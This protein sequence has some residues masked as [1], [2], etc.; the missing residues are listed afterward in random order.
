MVSVYFMSVITL[1]A[2]GVLVYAIY[3]YRHIPKATL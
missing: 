2:L 3:D 1:I